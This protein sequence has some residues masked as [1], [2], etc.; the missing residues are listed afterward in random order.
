MSTGEPDYSDP[1]NWPLGSRVD[2]K[3]ILPNRGLLV[4]ML[5]Q[6]Y[7]RKQV[8]PTEPLL[9]FNYT[10]KATFDR[11]WNTATRACRGLIIN[12]TDYTVVARGMEKFF[13]WNEPDAPEIKPD[14]RVW[15]T[16]K[17]DGSLGIRYW[18][19]RAKKWAIAT[20]GSFTSEQAI[21]ATAKL[22]EILQGYHHLE[23]E[24]L[25]L[26]YLYEII[27]PSNRIV[28]DYGDRDT[29]VSI[30]G[31]V[32]AT[33]EYI[34]VTE[35]NRDVILEHGFE[36]TEILPAKT[37]HEALNLPDRKNAEGIVVLSH[38]N[39]H[40][41]VKIKQ[42]DYV[43]MHRTIS[44]LSAKV[45]WERAANGET[46]DQIKWGMPEE[47]WDFIT[48]TYDDLL[49]EFCNITRAANG[50]HDAIV[51]YLNDRHGEYVWGRKD[52]AAESAQSTYRD[53]L[54]LLLDERDIKP[55]VWKKIKPEGDGRPF[56]QTSE[57]VA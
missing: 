12:H 4:S 52:Y 20:R 30:G 16:D 35:W 37:F 15:V 55:V 26:T 53:L 28:L 17:L 34:A 6:G 24:N 3:D 42:A 54:F 1:K 9:I 5:E 45:I 23:R 38:E 10:E 14:E 18:Q 49:E 56:R 33:G 40:R 29:L 50:T 27:Y 8:H 7:I 36:A 41:M 13:N 21:H 51:A 22:D 47:L 2:L 46:L 19:P 25:G 39:P 43:V 48:A 44:H 31:V 32:N 11:V 57:D